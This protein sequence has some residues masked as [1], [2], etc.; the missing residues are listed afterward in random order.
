MLVNV[1]I[2]LS[3]AN[4]IVNRE[5]RQTELFIIKKSVKLHLEKRMLV[6]YVNYFIVGLIKY[7]L[8]KI[9]QYLCT[10]LIK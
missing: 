3:I 5:L 1:H 2:N 6:K 7:I 4:I 8:N 9:N 10:N